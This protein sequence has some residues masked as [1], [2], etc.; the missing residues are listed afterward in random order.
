META[1][2]EPWTR[3][4]PTT[5]SVNPLVPTI[6][7][8]LIGAE[9]RLQCETFLVDSGADISLAPRGLCDALGLDWNAGQP[10][11]LNGISPR[12]ECA[13]EARV[14]EIEFLIPAASISV[15]VP[16]CFADGDTSQ[17]LGREGFFDC[18]RIEFDKPNFVTRFE[19]VDDE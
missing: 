16:V 8:V 15:A 11:R 19:L 10:T 9:G 5:E 6:E 13:V 14:F 1:F 3:L 12:P 18:F 17:I 2:V 7:V 4:L